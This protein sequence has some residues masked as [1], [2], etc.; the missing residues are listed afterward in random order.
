MGKDLTGH[1]LASGEWAL[2]CDLTYGGPPS[3]VPQIISQ[4]LWLNPLQFYSREGG[5]ALER[6]QRGGQASGLGLGISRPL[7]PGS[8]SQLYFLATNLQKSN[9]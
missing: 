7:S 8:V 2:N 6:E 3:A 4:G 9:I 1:S 5:T